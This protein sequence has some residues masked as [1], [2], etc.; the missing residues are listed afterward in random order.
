M[1]SFL[2]I[3]HTLFIA[4]QNTLTFCI[5]E[6]KRYWIR[7]KS[8]ALQPANSQMASKVVLAISLYPDKLLHKDKRVTIV[9][10]DALTMSPF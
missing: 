9:Q 7:A 2:R 3:F 4:I 5:L 6:F 10:V 1:K 8:R